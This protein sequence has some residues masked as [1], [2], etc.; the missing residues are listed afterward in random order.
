MAE[1]K[2]GFLLYADQKEL[3]DQLPNEKA[4]ELIKFIF[5]YVNDENPETTDLLLNLA[6]T[7]IKQQLKRDLVKYENKLDKKSIAGREG[8]LKRWY[9]DVYNIY[10]TTELTLEDA[11]EMAKGRK[12]SHTDKVQSQPIAKIADNDNDNDN[13]TVKDKDILFKERKEKFILWFNQQRKLKTGKLGKVKMLS[14]T[15]TNNLKQLLKDYTIEEFQIA[16]NN[17]HL[18]PWAVENKQCNTSHFLRVDNFNR[19]LNEGDKTIKKTDNL[20]D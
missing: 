9:L 4:G 10:K 2:K 1:D 7:P 18:S 3:F 15:D 12:A 16:F 20:Y 14:K 6:F 8:N 17:M 11:E 13:D 19:Y 5:A